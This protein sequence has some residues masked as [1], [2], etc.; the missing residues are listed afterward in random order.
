MKNIKFKSIMPLFV[1]L[2]ILLGFIPVLR[3]QS[4]SLTL[5]WN[6]SP[7]A[8]SYNVKRSTTSGAEVTISTTATTTFVDSS[9]VAG[10]KYFYVVTAVNSFGES[11][12][13][14][15][16]SGTF[17]GNPPAAPTGLQVVAN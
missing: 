7:T 11:G 8:T 10:T 15:E 5:T 12:P 1:L 6:A 14:S 3:G 9:G 17:L 4:H 13:S 16:V 2:G